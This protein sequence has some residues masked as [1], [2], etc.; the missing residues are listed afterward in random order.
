M[1]LLAGTGLN[2]GHSA[3]GSE[4]AG[5]VSVGQVGHTP[6]QQKKHNRN[7]F[8]D[9]HYNLEINLRESLG[10][11]TQDILDKTYI[12]GTVFVPR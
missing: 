10:C 3:S 2:G 9:S 6:G 8:G 7:Y 1:D 11:S 12:A 5:I 4:V